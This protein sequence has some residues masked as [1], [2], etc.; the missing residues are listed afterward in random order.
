MTKDTSAL[1]EILRALKLCARNQDN[2]LS[3][4]I[5]L[6]KNLFLAAFLQACF[7]FCPGLWHSLWAWP[8][9][10]PLLMV[11][12]PSY[13]AVAVPGGYF[14]QHPCSTL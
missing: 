8:P 3:L 7:G 9:V 4:S 2:I 5:A 14:E 13:G 11:D 6:S 12:D 10:G 1:K